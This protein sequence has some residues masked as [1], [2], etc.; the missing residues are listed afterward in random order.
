L[1]ADDL[2]SDF[3]WFTVFFG[4]HFILPYSRNMVIGG[5]KEIA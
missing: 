3:T 5:L 4:W 1:L 2:S